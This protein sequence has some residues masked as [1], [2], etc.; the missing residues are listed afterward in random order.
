M[1]LAI[2]AVENLP[3]WIRLLVNSSDPLPPKQDEAMSTAPPPAVPKTVETT[4]VP[5]T[6]PGHEAQSG[7][8]TLTST[9]PLAGAMPK[10]VRFDSLARC[11]DEIWIENDGQIY[12]LRRTRQGKLILTK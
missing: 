5:A 7:S 12:R 4:D 9:S 6:M 3:A 2:L 10:I 11:G 1:I 8:P